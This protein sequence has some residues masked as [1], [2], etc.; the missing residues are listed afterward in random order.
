MTAVGNYIAGEWIAPSN[1]AANISPSNLSDTVGE[2]AEGDAGDVDAAV[3][4]ARAAFPA[5][6]R[7]VPYQRGV[8]L[9]KVAAELDARRD[10]LGRLLAREEGKTLPEA[11]GEVIRAAQIFDY[12]SAETVRIAG[13]TLAAL[14][15]DVTVEI[16]L[17][18]IGVIGVIT[19]WNFPLAIPAWKIAAALAYGNCVV[20]K[21][22]ELV[23]ASA[24]ELVRILERS[25]LPAGVMNLVMG[26]GGSVGQRIVEH[27][28]IAAVTFT[29]SVP[30]GRRIAAGAIATMKKIQLELGGKNP[31]VVL[32]DADLDNA[33]ET[34][35][36]GAYY[37]T[38]QK[39]TAS[40]RLIVTE[41][42]HDRFVA[43][44]QE[45]MAQLVIDDALE[46]GAQIG[47]VVDSRQLRIDMDY[48]EIGR[49]EGA[50][51]AAGG[52]RLERRHEGFY[53]A[54]TLFV[55][56]TPAM[57]I[58]REEI[59]GPVAA[60][61][62]VKDYEEALTVA[63][64][65]PFGLSSGICTTSLKYAAHFKRNSD[66][67]MVKVNVATTGADFHLP[68]GGRKDSSYGPHEQGSH[69]REFFTQFKTAYQL[70]L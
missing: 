45:R 17:E 36:D 35:V 61:I 14:R 16:T 7:S 40:S 57:R 21:P 1:A 39:C 3:A 60:V 38:G 4:A 43:A 51:I 59:F 34:A 29:G 5:W 64:D 56:A 44:M 12:F 30:T 41:G 54:P 27:P 18:P 8:I 15:A 31:L 52:E 9:R 22:S 70:A 46:P 48:I 32:D 2:F 20:F 13:D 11:I 28:R 69:A 63:N 37:A 68:S 47:P 26:Q 50:R 55:D 6:S 33:V 10:D 23:P 66:A 53:L 19:P 65:T 49:S 42:I 24:C 58:C 62:R 67:G 25:G